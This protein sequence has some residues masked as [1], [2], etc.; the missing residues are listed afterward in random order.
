MLER[1]LNYEDRNPTAGQINFADEVSA[2]SQEFLDETNLNYIMR[3]YVTRGVL[4]TGNPRRP[5]Y[6]DFM[7]VGDYLDAQQKFITAREQF[8]TLPAKLRHQLNNNPAEFL[9]WIA[10]PANHKTAQDLGLIEQATTPVP[11]ASAAPAA[12][13][14]PPAGSTATPTPS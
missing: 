5:I 13:E 6:G 1:I 3:R 7:E 10:D 11:P 2:T 4:P 12:S 8:L 14:S 9:V